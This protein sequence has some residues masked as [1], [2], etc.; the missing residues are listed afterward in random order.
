VIDEDTSYWLAVIASPRNKHAAMK[1]LNSSVKRAKRFP[2]RIKGDACPSYPP[3]C[4]AILPASVFQDFKSK[5]EAY[6][7]INIVER[8]NR[9]L[10]KSLPAGER[11]F[12]T[13][14]AL[15]YFVEL[16]RFYYNY[17]RPHRGLDGRTPAEEAGSSSLSENKWQS[18]ITLAY[19]HSSDLYGKDTILPIVKPI[20]DK[21]LRQMSIDSPIWRNRTSSNAGQTEL[22]L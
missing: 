8:L 1:A 4:N 12:R 19:A 6:G 22:F 5:K 7:H 18:L 17:I 2:D 16:V 11:R 20:C 13:S 3:A 9:T 14:E 15:R 10:R 21:N